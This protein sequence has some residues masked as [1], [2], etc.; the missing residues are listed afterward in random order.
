MRLHFL[1]VENAVSCG[2][3]LDGLEVSFDREDAGSNEP[4]SPICLLGPNGSGKSQLLQIL[5]EIIQ[6]AW[7]AHASGEERQVANTNALFELEYFLRPKKNSAI[8]HVRLSRSATTKPAGHVEMSIRWRDRWKS[9]PSNTPKFGKHLPPLVV[10][11]TSGDNETLSL[12]FFVSRSGYA[13]DV[14]TA[15]LNPAKNGRT[16]PNNR[17]ILIDYATH[18][19][20]LVANLLLGSSRIRQSV[21]RHTAVDRLASCRCVIQLNHRIAPKAPRKTKGRKGIQLTEE[22]EQYIDALRRS[23]TCWSYEE[24]TETYIFDYFFDDASRRAFSHFF[25]TAITLYRAFH[26]LA[27]LNDLVISKRARRRL[28]REVED[29]R[30][31]SRLPEPQD[32]DK[33]FRFEQVRFHCKEK[34]ETPEP[35]DYVSLSDGEHQQAQ[36]FGVFAMITD[37][38]VLFLLDEPESHFN[39]QWRVQFVKRLLELPVTRRGRQE[40]LITTHA[41][42]LP[43]DMPRDH[44]LIFKK[45]GEKITITRPD[46]ETFGATF[47]RI[48]EHCFHVRPPISQLALDEINELQ[49][50]GTSRQIKDGMNRLGSS[51]E[52]AFLADRLRQLEKRR[53]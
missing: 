45:S 41:P 9:V 35:V 12:P 38:D 7:Y 29:R 49:K 22:L 39:P 24:K 51:V 52:K 16:I 18:L 26:K 10:G 44:V 34:R 30:F 46:V 21:L 8:A 47:D 5:A 23:A 11:Y 50:R 25:H 19:E 4:L 37:S 36:I 13:H 6:S 48:L 28:K 17:L 3:L 27:L 2:G 1:K 33:V 53:S 32:E 31:A 42:F 15:A 14:T 20:V 43:S 40:V